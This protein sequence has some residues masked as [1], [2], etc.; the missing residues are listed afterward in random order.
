[1]RKIY[2]W[3]SILGVLFLGMNFSFCEGGQMKVSFQQVDSLNLRA[4]SYRYKDLDIA[5]QMAKEAFFLAENY[6]SGKAQALN[7]WGFCRFM[8]MDF[9]Q[10]DSLFQVVY[11]TT[12]NELELLVADVGMMKICQRTAQNKEFYDYRNSALSRINRFR[13]DEDILKNQAIRNRFLYA[14]SEFYITS[15]IYYFYFH[16]LLSAKVRY[17]VR[18]ECLFS[19]RFFTFIFFAFALFTSA[20]AIQ[21]AEYAFGGQGQT[22]Q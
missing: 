19:V 12:S 9:E 14:Q 22:A 18:L 11:E 10:S 8:K 15:S 16:R 20:V 4:Y 6:P 2:K 5:E 17:R 1:M 21:T 3:I 13:E 7:H